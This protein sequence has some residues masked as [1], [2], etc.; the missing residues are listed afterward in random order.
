MPSI[1]ISLLETLVT[2]PM[3]IPLEDTESDELSL[4]HAVRPVVAIH[5]NN[6]VYKAFALFLLFII[7]SP[8]GAFSFY[9][10][11]I[12]FENDPP[13]KRICI[14]RELLIKIARMHQTSLSK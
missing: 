8:F 14:L 10:S 2:L 6:A 5:N 1:W 13:V 7:I 3:T 11:I 12:P 4:P 9:V